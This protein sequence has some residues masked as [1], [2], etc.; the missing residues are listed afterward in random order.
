MTQFYADFKT[1]WSA[2][3]NLLNN[4]IQNVFMTNIIGE[5]FFFLLIVGIFMTVLYYL[6]HIID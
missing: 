2:L 6:V 4:I 3:L 1:F 5:I